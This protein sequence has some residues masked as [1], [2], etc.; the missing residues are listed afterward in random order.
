MPLYVLAGREKILSAELYD[1]LDAREGGPL[2]VWPEAP[3]GIRVCNPYFEHIPLLRVTLIIT[4]AGP[5]APADIS[6]A[7]LTQGT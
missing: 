1:R 7:R 2:E 4:D 3:E 6:N 5:V